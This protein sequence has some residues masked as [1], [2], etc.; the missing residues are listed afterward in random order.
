MKPDKEPDMREVNAANA[1]PM[2]ELPL[3]GY[4][5]GKPKRITIEYDDNSSTCIG[6]IESV[7][8]IVSNLEAHANIFNALQLAIYS[9]TS[10]CPEENDGSHRPIISKAVLTKLRQALSTIITPT[11]PATIQGDI[12]AAREMLEKLLPMLRDP[13]PVGLDEGGYPEYKNDTD[14]G[15]AAMY[16]YASTALTRLMAYKG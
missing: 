13:E 11:L 14:M 5:G 10:L 2:T 6:N 3:K 15:D 9:I 12:A 7:G 1:E 16:F 8:N 4:Y